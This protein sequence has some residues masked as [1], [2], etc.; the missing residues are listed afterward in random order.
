M[1]D[2]LP[3]TQA[4]PSAAGT[5]PAATPVQIPDHDLLRCVGKGSY[6]EVWLARSLTGTFRAVKIISRKTFRDDRP[7][8][9]EFA[10]IQKFEAISRTHPGL[11]SILHVGR[12][13]SEGYLYYVMEVA[14]DV[15]AGAAFQSENYIPKAL[16]VRILRQGLL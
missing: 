4:Q 6:G 5:L 8:E 16:S 2:P 15:N 9:R 10:G 13:L 12:N 1:R 14:D 3:D 11:V 7:F